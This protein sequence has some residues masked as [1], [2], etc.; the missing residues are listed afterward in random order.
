M[1]TIDKEDLTR[2]LEEMINLLEYDSMRSPG[3]AK[4][5]SQH[6]HSMYWLLQNVYISQ[7]LPLRQQQRRITNH[8]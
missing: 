5:N 1:K 7:Y 2:N 6:L 8:D 3:K 4:L